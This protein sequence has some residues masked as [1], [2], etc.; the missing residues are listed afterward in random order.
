MVGGFTVAAVAVDKGSITSNLLLTCRGM[1]HR[2]HPLLAILIAQRVD[3][4]HISEGWTRSILLRG[5]ASF[6]ARS[7]K[8][9]RLKIA[10]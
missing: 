1:R 10:E 4:R 7:F 5:P 9:E 6:F 3:S 2:L 8:F